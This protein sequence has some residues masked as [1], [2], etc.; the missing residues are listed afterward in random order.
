MIIRENASESALQSREIVLRIAAWHDE[1]APLKILAQELAPAA[2]SMAPGITGIFTTCHGMNKRYL[3]GGSG[4][5]KPQPR[6]VHFS[7]L[8][9][10]TL[11]PM[12]VQVGGGKPKLVTYDVVKGLRK[13]DAKNSAIVTSV[14]RT[15]PVMSNQT[16]SV[17]LIRIAWAR[18]GDKGNTANIGVI[19]RRP[20]FYSILIQEL[21]VQRVQH[22]MQHVA[23]G[24]ITRFELPGLNAVNFVLT[25]SLGLFFFVLR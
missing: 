15:L 8:I 23:K 3:G 17:P 6:L 1:E 21:T 5:P 22:F 2:T 24:S 7:G 25:R 18:S 20:E 14:P 19:A 9:P 10:K 16:T 4:R 11:V 13:M 12:M